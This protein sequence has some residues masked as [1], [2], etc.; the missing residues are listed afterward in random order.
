MRLSHNGS[1][2][3]HS[4]TERSLC[5]FMAMRGL[6]QQGLQGGDDYTHAMQCAARC[7][8]KWVQQGLHGEEKRGGSRE[9]VNFNKITNRI[10]GLSKGPPK[11]I[12]NHQKSQ[13]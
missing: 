4:L 1:M 9:D 3:N 13:L 8:A 2:Q 6:M 12:S 10:K 5:H 7:G 11:S